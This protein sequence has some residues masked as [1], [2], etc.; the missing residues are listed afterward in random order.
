MENQNNKLFQ[1]T[2]FYQYKGQI[3]EEY[4][5]SGLLLSNNYILKS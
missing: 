4:T 3:K 5:W 2:C 1:A